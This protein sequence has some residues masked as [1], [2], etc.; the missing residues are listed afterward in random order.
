MVII[1]NISWEDILTKRSQILERDAKLIDKNIRMIESQRK[2]IQRQTQLLEESHERIDT[3][4][5]QQEINDLMLGD[6][7]YIKTGSQPIHRPGKVDL[8]CNTIMRVRLLDDENTVID[9]YVNLFEPIE[10]T[11][12]MLVL[13]GF[14]KSENADYF[15]LAGFPFNISRYS[16]RDPSVYEVSIGTGGVIRTI[17]YVHEL[18]N[19]LCLFEY[20]DLANN[21]KI[22]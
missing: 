17:K 8:L 10:L 20:R 2:E 12:D 9:E 7:V 1:D 5:T 22:K 13:N 11:N 16:Y 18:Q 6:L 4:I 15:W 3:P 14:N 21:F 19:L